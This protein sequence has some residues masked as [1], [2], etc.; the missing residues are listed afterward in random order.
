MHR[1]AFI[2][3]VLLIASAT[4]SADPQQQIWPHGLDPEGN[5][6]VPSSDG[7]PVR[8]AEAGHCN[9]V[10]FA[11]DGRTAGCR[12]KQENAAGQPAAT[13]QLEI[14]MSGPRT[15]IISPGAPI[16]DWHF[17]NDAKQISVYWGDSN[18]PAMYSLYDAASGNLVEQLAEPTDLRTLPQW[19]KTAAELEIEGVPQSPALD[20]ERTDWISS[21]LLRVER[22]QPGMHRK[23]LLELFAT[24]GGVSTRTQRVY[25]LREC[26][27][28]KITVRFKQGPNGAN[29]WGE[30]L[31][32]VIESI[33]EPFLQFSKVD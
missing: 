18:G 14:Y 11:P 3:A 8:V 30:S 26:P 21:V 28:I 16:R 19:A 22:I 10:R 4:C 32:D 29:A 23:D 20:R 31:D 6:F 27:Y 25:V 33:S 1:A 9:E 13:L 17:W 12:V 7:S 15:T 2:P 24:E 5:V